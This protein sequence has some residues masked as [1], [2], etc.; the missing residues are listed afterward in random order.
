[1]IFQK[2]L[3]GIKVLKEF[4]HVTELENSLW[5]SQHL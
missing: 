5:S 1:M 3:I 4:S 2:Q